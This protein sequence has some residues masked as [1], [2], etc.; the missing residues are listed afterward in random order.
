MSLDLKQ[1]VFQ[2][3]VT[4]IAERKDSLRAIMRFANVGIEG[5][6][7]VEIVAALGEKVFSL[8]NKGP[9]LT[10]KDRTNIE[11]KAATNFGINW[12]VI[13]PIKKYGS[14]VLFLADGSDPNK[15]KFTNR[16]DTFEV[17]GCELVSD[18]ANN[19]LLGMAKPKS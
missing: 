17:I 14:P 3:V 4:R 18:G 2:P 1:D 7:K 16:D 6:F 9:D 11:I 13:D 10:L 8:N 5:W 12:C 19:W 15:Y